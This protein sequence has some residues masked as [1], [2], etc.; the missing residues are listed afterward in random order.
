MLTFNSTIWLYPQPIDFRKQ[1]DGLVLLV[2]DHLHLNP[3]S[4][5]MF[6]FRNQS[7]SK[8]KILWWDKNGFENTCFYSIIRVFPINKKT[9]D[10]CRNNHELRK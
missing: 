9:H 7:A 6:L 3:T 8:I 10:I 1:I 4:G 2:A 5:Q